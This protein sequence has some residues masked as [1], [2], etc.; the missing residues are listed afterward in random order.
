[1]AGARHRSPG[2]SVRLYEGL[3]SPVPAD[4]TGAAARQAL[5]QAAG[6]AVWMNS[7]VH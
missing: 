2:A 5:A 3:A 7:T 4:G 1:M 6:W